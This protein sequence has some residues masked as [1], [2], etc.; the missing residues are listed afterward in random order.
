MTVI[1]VLVAVLVAAIVLLAAARAKKS[2]RNGGN[3]APRKAN[4]PERNQAELIE[5]PGID[6]F[7]AN[8]GDIAEKIMK[9]LDLGARRG[10]PVDDTEDAI[11]RILREKPLLWPCF[12]RWRAFVSTHRDKGWGDLAFQM[13]DPEEQTKRRALV[14]TY[15]SV[16]SAR[17][18]IEHLREAGFSQAEVSS[19]CDTECCFIC[20]ELHGKTLPLDDL[21][22]TFPPH[23]CC[24]C[25]LIASSEDL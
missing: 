11:A 18:E 23:P 22:S 14:W 5:L 10:E 17:R 8:S 13:G 12:E 6:F 1:L 20:R 9:R 4:A 25:T 15:G 19:S 16:F 3:V 7:L 21:E 2:D 24:R